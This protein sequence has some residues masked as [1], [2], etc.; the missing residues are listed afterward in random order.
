MTM[1]HPLRRRRFL[2]LGLAAGGGLLTARFAFA[3]PAASDA[4]FVFIILRGALDGLAA[5]PAYTDPDYVRLR[6]QLAIAP[7]GAADGAL[8]L[9]G[10]F[11]L[12]PGLEFVHEAYG[13]GEALILHAIAT[14]Y[15]DRSHFDG[16]DVLESGLTQPH[17]SQTGWLNRAVGVL[18]ASIA[19]GAEGGVALGQNV[20]LVLRG[21]API[22]SW[23]PSKLPQIDDDTL[24]RIADRYAG[25]ALLSQRLGEAMATDRIAAESQQMRPAAPAGATAATSM[26][27]AAGGGTAK[28]PGADRY[29]ET[30]RAAAGFIQREDGP[31]VAVFDTI[32]WDTHFNEGGAQGQLTQRLRALDAA[33]RALKQSLGPA[34]ARTAILIATEFGRTAAANGTRGTD[35]GTATAAFLLGGA[36]Q[37]GRVLCDWPG[38]SAGALYQGRDLRATMDVRSVIQSVLHDH[39][40]VSSRALAAEVF[41]GAALPPVPDLIRA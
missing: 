15:R 40:H 7:P 38:L 41:P 9:D 26:D 11:G 31:A 12:N 29:L 28:V 14:P 20:P 39:L 1:H 21:P 6:E 18:P 2:Q 35:H 27:A 37:G 33:L 24:Q 13:A 10:H 8:A 30:V 16:Q 34:W 3:A 4:R 5:V 32:G 23:S 17:A 36:V 19:H 25:D 22:A